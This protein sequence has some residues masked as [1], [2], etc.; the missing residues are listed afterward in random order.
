MTRKQK[1]LSVIGGALLFLG[2]ATALTFVALGQKASYLY[3]P[4][5]LKTA[6]VEPG[7][8]IRLG[9]LFIECAVCGERQPQS[10]TRQSPDARRQWVAMH[11]ACT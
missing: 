6:S 11:L 1:R 10:R 7:Q 4:A 9:G 2:A 8:R 3:M 5:D